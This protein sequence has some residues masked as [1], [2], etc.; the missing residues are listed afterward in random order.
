M[1]LI[2]EATIKNFDGVIDV[3]V[4]IVTEKDGL[5]V[6]RKGYVYHIKSAW[7]VDKFL[8]NYRRGKKFHGLALQYLV[9]FQIK[10]EKNE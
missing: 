7:A 6:K 8:F 4:H 1:Y 3:T 9:N 5:P 2:H 10:E